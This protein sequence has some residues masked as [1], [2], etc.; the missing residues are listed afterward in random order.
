MS[1]REALYLFA[2]V[3]KVQDDGNRAMAV[4]K[5][6]A[7]AAEVL[8]EAAPELD[9]IAHQYGVF[10]VGTRLRELAAEQQPQP[11]PAPEAVTVYR[12]SHDAIVMGLYTNARAA[13]A[14]CEDE[15]RRAWSK[16]EFDW[17]EDEED[18]VAELVVMTADGEEPTGYV[19][20]PLAAEAEYD[21]EADA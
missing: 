17:I 20:T 18:G 10:G 8:R 16:V 2:M 14:H 21:P 7:H 13:R 4:S 12:A 15:E 1:A 19:V 11:T 5:L 6:N 9:A 3:G